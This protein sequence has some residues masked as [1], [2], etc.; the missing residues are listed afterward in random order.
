MTGDGD[1]LPGRSS[2]MSPAPPSPCEDLKGHGTNHDD[3]LES[4]HRK[5]MAWQEGFCQLG[6]GALAGNGIGGNAHVPPLAIFLQLKTTTEAFRDLAVA[7][8]RVPHPRSATV[9]AA[10]L[11]AAEGLHGALTAEA[12]SSWRAAVY[13]GNLGPCG[14]SDIVEKIQENGSPSVSKCGGG[15]EGI[16]PSLLQCWKLQHVAMRCASL[17]ASLFLEEAERCAVILAS[18]GV[19]DRGTAAIVEAYRLACLW[20]LHS[21][22]S[23]VRSCKRLRDAAEH[24]VD[25]ANT[26]RTMGKSM[27]EASEVTS[28]VDGGDDARSTESSSWACFMD[29]QESLSGVMYDTYVLR[30]LGVGDWRAD[31]GTVGPPP[32]TCAASEGDLGSLDVVLLGLVGHLYERDKKH[33][34]QRPNPRSLIDAEQQSVSLAGSVIRAGRAPWMACSGALSYALHALD[35]LEQAS[36]PGCSSSGSSGYSITRSSSKSRSNISLSSSS[37]TSLGGASKRSSGNSRRIKTDSRRGITKAELTVAV[38]ADDIESET[39]SDGGTPSGRAWIAVARAILA[40]YSQVASGESASNNLQAATLSTSPMD[41][42]AAIAD[43]AMLQLASEKHPAL[44]TARKGGI[45]PLA[46]ALLSAGRAR[47]LVLALV[48]LTSCEYGSSIGGES[49]NT[50]LDCRC[51]NAFRARD[52]SFKTS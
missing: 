1:H 15:I 48:R 35:Q 52:P 17:M 16:L 46:R 36:S 18:K 7:E 24:L 43:D 26:T 2:A 47:P 33:G 29:L 11:A 9:L 51:V 41:I 42:A 22:E 37:R 12:L 27:T 49:Q 5:C 28:S 25:A 23:I 14:E 45:G 38:P 3:F 13:G 31:E 8:A 44:I 6:E 30:A 10:F 21:G 19:T 32:L 20:L 50:G 40:G 34:L 4:W 39:R